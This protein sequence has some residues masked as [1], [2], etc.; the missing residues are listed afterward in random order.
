MILDSQLPSILWA[1]A[2]NTA[3][4]R[5][6]QSPTVANKGMTP[7]QKLYGRKPEISHLRH[8]GCTAYRL[9]PAYQRR[10]KFTA[11]V[12][13]VYMLGYVPNSTTL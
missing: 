5:H 1:E 6:A 3:N 12:E 7:Y 13:V 9:L 10:G 11:R 2:I 4:Y 8:F